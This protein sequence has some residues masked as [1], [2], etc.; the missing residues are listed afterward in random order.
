MKIRGFSLIELIFV[1]VVIGII[2]TIAIPKL[3]NITEKATVS[4][5]KKDITTTITA[6]QSYYVLNKNIEKISDSVNLNSSIWDISD[7]KVVF[8]ENNKDCVTI[9]V[10]TNQLT[11]SIDKTSGDICKELFDEGIKDTVYDLK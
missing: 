3:T 1:L 9:E 7:K 11:L 2:A 6:I 8:K 10:T 5:L 4:S